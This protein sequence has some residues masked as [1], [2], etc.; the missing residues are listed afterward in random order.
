M[1]NFL[2]NSV[3]LPDINEVWTDKEEM[4]Y[5]FIVESTSSPHTSGITLVLTERKVH[6]YSTL[7]ISCPEDPGGGTKVHF[8]NVV[9]GK[10]VY[11]SGFNG[12]SYAYIGKP[13]LWTSTDLE[14]LA[15]SDPVPVTP[16]TIDRT[17]MLLGWL[18][19]RQIAGQR[20]YNEIDA[21]LINGVL[22]I[23][24]AKAYLNDNVLEVE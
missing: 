1:A 22:Y 5:A 2:Y 10:W 3:E 7:S 16:S 12:G 23:K 8:Y 9:N 15:A 20:T 6:I 21:E 11:I 4:P 14:Y 17:S 18:M 13:V 24:N 19:G